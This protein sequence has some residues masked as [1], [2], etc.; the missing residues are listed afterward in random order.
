MGIVVIAS[1]IATADAEMEQCYRIRAE[2]F[3]GEQSVPADLERDEYDASALH[4]L[5]C[6]DGRAIA[7]ARVVLKDNNRVAK[8]GRVAV[9]AAR[10]GLGIGRMLMAAIE[11]S[12]ELQKVERF[13]LEAQTHALQFYAQLGYVA[14]GEEFMD[15]GIPHRSMQKDNPNKIG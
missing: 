4:F 10:R 12:P 3:I 6:E 14:Y 1:K 5:T 15:A 9:I 11:Q 8:I 7:A 13:A 2:V